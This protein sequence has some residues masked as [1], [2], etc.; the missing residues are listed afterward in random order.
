[1]EELWQKVIHPEMINLYIWFFAGYVAVYALVVL[2]F[3]RKGNPP[4]GKTKEGQAYR[5]TLTLLWLH[6]LVGLIL[7]SWRYWAWSVARDLNQAPWDCWPL[8]SVYLLCFLFNIYLIFFVF[9]PTYKGY[10]RVPT[11]S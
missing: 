4:R 7:A 3:P 11:I 1:M 6:L 10:R 8:V 9:G 5:R 2:F